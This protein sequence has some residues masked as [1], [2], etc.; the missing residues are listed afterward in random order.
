[1]KRLRV[2]RMLL[3]QLPAGQWRYLMPYERF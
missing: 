3:S 2:G 1:M